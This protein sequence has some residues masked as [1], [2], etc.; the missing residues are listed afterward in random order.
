M[1]I[2]QRPNPYKPGTKEY[3]VYRLRMPMYEPYDPPMD[4]FIEKQGVSIDNI[5]KDEEVYYDDKQHKYY[6]GNRIYVSATTI[7]SHFHE[8]FDTQGKAEWMAHRYGQ[9]P[10]Y[11]INEWRGI[12]QQSLNRGNDKHDK[13]EQF[14]YNRGFTSVT[15]SQRV[16]HI[17]RQHNGVRDNNSTKTTNRS[18]PIRTLVDG[19]YPE[20]KLWRH[21]WGIA[22]RC[23]K[24]TLETIQSI[25][26]AHIEDW[27][28]NKV[29]ETSGYINKH[30]QERMML[31]PIE[32]L[33]DCE[34]THYTLQ[35]SIYQYMLEYFDYQPGLRRIIH[36]PHEIEGLGIPDPKPYDLP[37]LRDE[38]E[39]MLYTLKER[40]ILYAT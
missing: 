7:V 27:K 32:H 8:K 11:W 3:Q 36:F 9:T 24:P 6:L 31:Y 30:G 10:E 40:R 13:Q 14:L 34:L 17:V 20:L 19:C 25:R 38:V 22:G 28:T 12:N 18:T 26:Y 35:L 16:S 1:Q 37:Y 23:D 4:D 2:K 5:I 39:S 21:D 29:I 33:P 15:G